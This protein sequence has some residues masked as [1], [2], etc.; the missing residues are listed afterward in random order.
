[1]SEYFWQYKAWGCQVMV[2]GDESRVCSSPGV[3]IGVYDPCSAPPPWK[4]VHLEGALFFS[5]SVALPPFSSKSGYLT[6]SNFSNFFL[7]QSSP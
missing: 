1:M 7:F 6:P 2:R 3:K 5:F 4:G